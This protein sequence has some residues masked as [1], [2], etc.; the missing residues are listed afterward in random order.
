LDAAILRFVDDFQSIIRAEV[1]RTVRR[2]LGGRTVPARAPRKVTVEVPMRGSATK[3]AR[4]ARRAVASSARA[5]AAPANSKPARG[6]RAAQGESD[7]AVKPRRK[8]PEQ[9]SLF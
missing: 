1:E 7:S 3:K 5:K 6:K 8:R 2:S 9:L 4:A